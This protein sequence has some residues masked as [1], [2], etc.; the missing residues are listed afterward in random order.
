MCNYFSAKHGKAEADGVIGHLSMHIDAV[1]RSGSHELAN[2]GEILWYCHLK[3]GI[4]NDNSEMCCHWQRHYFKVLSIKHDQNID[5]KTVKGTLNFHSV[6]NVGLPGIIEV[7]ES[8]C[9]CEPS[10]FNEPGNCKNAWLVERLKM[11]FKIRFGIAIH[12]PTDI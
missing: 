1:V 10:F 4:H 3:L 2:A 12:C 11:T 8:S 6:R 9:F 5:C 7:R